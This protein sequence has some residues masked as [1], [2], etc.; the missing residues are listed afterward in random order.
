MQAVVVPLRISVS[1]KDARDGAGVG[2]VGEGFLGWIDVV[3]DPL[4][5]LLAR[6]RDHL[7]LHIVHM[8]VYEAGRQDAA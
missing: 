2:L 6:R 5:Q 4:Q 8:G 1:Q 3:V 7:G